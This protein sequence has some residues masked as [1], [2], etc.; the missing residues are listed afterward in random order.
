M[1]EQQTAC[2]RACAGLNVVADNK[3]ATNKLNLPHFHLIVPLI[4][5]AAHQFP[6]PHVTGLNL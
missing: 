3:D 4:I 2:Q 1:H 6:V 5:S